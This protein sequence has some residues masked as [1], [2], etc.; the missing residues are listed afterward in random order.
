MIF[1]LQIS[2][3]HFS[4]TLKNVVSESLPL[5]YFVKSQ[6]E[7]SLF[8]EKS[9]NYPAWYIVFANATHGYQ[10][11]KNGYGCVCAAATTDY[12]DTRV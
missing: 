11:G 4:K 3:T 7:F 12:M 8:S 6:N 1:D 9:V 10:A 5:Y 2:K